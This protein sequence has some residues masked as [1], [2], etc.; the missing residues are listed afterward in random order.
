MVIYTALLGSDQ[1]GTEAIVCIII[2]ST[3]Y[4]TSLWTQTLLGSKKKDRFVVGK[5]ILVLIETMNK[6][7]YHI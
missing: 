3:W 2:I 1:S 5:T 6:C 4:S 7:A